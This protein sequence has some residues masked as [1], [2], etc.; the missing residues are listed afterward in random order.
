VFTV[1]G[2]T[3]HCVTCGA[4]RSAFGRFMPEHFPML[5]SPEKIADQVRQLAEITR[6]PIFFVGDLRDG[7]HEYVND[8]LAVLRDA[9]VSNRIVFEFFHPPDAEL[10]AAIDRS[11]QHWGA[12]LSPESHD[13]SVRERLGKARY[14][15]AHMETA[16]KAILGSRCEQLDLFYMVG[17]PG[18]TRQ[19]V[20]ATVDAIERLF[21]RFDRR[22][23]AFITPMAPFLDPGS[24]GFEHPEK[25]GYTLFAHT[26][27]EH[28]ALLEQNDWQSMLNYETRWMTR[29]EIVEST[30]VA[31]ARLNDVKARHGRI[32]DK[33]ALFP[34]GAFLR[35]FRIGGIL[36]LLA[37][38]CLTWLRSRRYTAGVAPG[39]C[40][41]V[42]TSRS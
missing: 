19:S 27:A 30:S 36:R 18:Q 15:N 2:C 20:L 33:S 35:N 14:T 42:H 3:R 13:E 38:E 41:G 1:R 26:L 23:S 34:T 17:L 12:E 5:R 37:R 7:G 21:E 25:H 22:L 16:I 29:A 10:V 8:V 32:S 4:S 6:A 9:P 11:V 28:R 24:D 39:V 40:E 31:A